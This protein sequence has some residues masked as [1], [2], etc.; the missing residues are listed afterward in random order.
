MQQEAQNEK[1]LKKTFKFHKITAIGISSNQMH[2]AG[3]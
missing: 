1:K 2:Y 3:N